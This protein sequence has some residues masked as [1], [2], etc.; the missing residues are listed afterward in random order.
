MKTADGFT[1]KFPKW[2]CTLMK[3]MEVKVCFVMSLLSWTLLCFWQCQWVVRGKGFGSKY[4][5]YFIWEM[6]KEFAVFLRELLA[7]LLLF[8]RCS[9]MKLQIV[10]TKSPFNA[11]RQGL[12]ESP[13]KLLAVRSCLKLS[14][15]KSSAQTWECFEDVKHFRFI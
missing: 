2:L 1:K 3:G 13:N 11:S 10:S 9:T 15:V 6:A 14:S 4:K 12:K 7:C 8:L 5:A